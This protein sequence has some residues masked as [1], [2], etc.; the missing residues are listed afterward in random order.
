MMPTISRRTFAKIVGGSALG[1]ASLQSRAAYGA[2]KPKIVVVG[3][4]A[5]GATAARYLATM[6]K[7]E[8]DITLVEAGKTYTT[9]FFSN[10]ALVGYRSF[11]SI[12]HSYDKLEN[13]YGIKRVEGWASKIDRKTRHV[14]MQDGSRIPYDRLLLSPGVD[15]IWDTIEGFGKEYAE[16]LPHAWKAGK[17]THIL[18]DQLMAMKD[19]GT[20]VM[21]PPREPYRCP[22]APYERASVI[23]NYFKK[24]KSKSKLLI[25]DSEEHFSKQGLFM[26]G[27]E[28]YYAGIVEWM[29]PSI[30]DG[31]KSIDVK[32]KI[33]KT[34]FEDVS[35]DV[36]NV[37]PPQKA[38]MI[39]EISGLTDK[40]GYCPINPHTLQSRMDDYIYIVGD[41]IDPG[42]MPKS[43][44]AANNQGKMAAISIVADLKSQK[45]FA[46]RYANVC[47]SYVENDDFVKIGGKYVGTDA[48]ILKQ[49]FFV[50]QREDKEAERVKNRNE[51]YGWYAGIT[52]DMF[53]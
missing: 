48:K 40:T 20:F 19:G 18:R 47:W 3:G 49:H 33:I 25:L 15:F 28:K 36:A 9:C 41:A 38:G 12:T 50:S 24:S 11:E 43:A 37:I 42:D 23:A 17:Q 10:L 26:D 2:G 39:A 7:N 32:G 16:T 34:G 1:L 29:P 52:K 13:E 14:V 35:F 51:A 53:G 22:S 6:L 31:I 5:G 46:A 27:W 44:F 30:H 8:A 4:G 21:L 45:R